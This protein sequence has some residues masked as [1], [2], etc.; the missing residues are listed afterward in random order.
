MLK[1]AGVFDRAGQ[2][3]ARGFQK[4]KGILKK[5]PPPPQLSGLTAGA[6]G[7][8]AGALGLG[9]MGALSADEGDRADSF[10]RNAVLGAGLGGAA[11]LIGKG[12]VNEMLAQRHK[13]KLMA[14]KAGKTKTASPK[15][16]LR[17]KDG[18]YT[19]VPAS[20]M[21]PEESARYSEQVRKRNAEGLK[22]TMAAR[23]RR[24]AQGL[25]AKPPS[26]FPKKTGVEGHA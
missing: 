7:A 15:H 5:D 14:A 24:V 3:A 6:A 13:L 17:S 23:R 20:E 25:P 16:F 4:L 19:W 18:K 1:E 21:T 11:G 12:P 22:T 10:T 2:S 9:T 8:G 26:L